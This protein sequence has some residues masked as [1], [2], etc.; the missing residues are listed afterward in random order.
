MLTFV[1][2]ENMM[3]FKPKQQQLK[4]CL[5]NAFETDKIEFSAVR[6][7]GLRQSIKYIYDNDGGGVDGVDD[8]DDDDNDGDDDDDDA[9]RPQFLHRVHHP[10]AAPVITV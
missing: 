10:A 8:D 2:C 7:G 4:I 5:N 6:E 9:S 3:R 1:V